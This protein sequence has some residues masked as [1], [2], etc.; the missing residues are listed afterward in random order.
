M[1][2]KHDLLIDDG[3]LLILET[4]LAVLIGDR[5]AVVLQQIHYWL[6]INRKAQK[7]DTHFFDEAWWVYNTWKE[8]QDKNFKFWPIITIRR[9]FSDLE[10]N[11]LIVTK[12]HEDRNKGLWITIN[13]QRLFDIAASPDINTL[14]KQRGLF[15]LSRR[16]IKLSKPPVQ[17]EQPTGTTETTETTQING[18]S[19]DAL[20]LGQDIMGFN[21]AKSIDG[22]HDLFIKSLH[23]P[24]F[25]PEPKNEHGAAQPPSVVPVKKSLREIRAEQDA[26]LRAIPPTYVPELLG[27]DILSVNDPRFPVTGKYIVQTVN[28]YSNRKTQ[29]LKLDVVEELTKPVMVNGVQYPSLEDYC[30]KYPTYTKIFISEFIPT[31]MA[32]KKSNVTV[33]ALTNL[34]LRYDAKYRGYFAWMA[35]N[36][37]VDLTAKT[38]DRTAPVN[39]EGEVELDERQWGE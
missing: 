31:W 3:Q 19:G 4:R 6:D 16:L 26:A 13:Y 22:M 11:G 7:Q 28:Q 12:S 32:S 24:S 23:I 2:N 37:H 8:W 14:K 10:S 34:L 25:Q 27:N 17:F 29:G 30:Q 15:K 35:A 5:Q 1:G 33:V 39:D 9:L 38:I 36:A 18:A 21:I 20:S